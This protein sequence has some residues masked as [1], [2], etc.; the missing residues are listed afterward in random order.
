MCEPVSTGLLIASIATTA[1]AGGVSAYAAYDQGQYQKAVGEYNA[2]VN[3]NEAQ[4]VLNKSR[5]VES[6]E[7]QKASELRSRQRAVLASRG[8]DVNSGSALSMQEDTTLIGEM[9][10]MRVRQNAEDRADALNQRADLDLSNGENAADQGT[11]GAVAAGLKT[12]GSIAGT[13]S[14]SGLF[15]K[16]SLVTDGKAGVVAD[17]WYQGG[18]DYEFGQFSGG[19]S[20]MVKSF[21]F[22]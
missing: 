16:G 14:N 7:R 17:K 11:M 5:I 6:E 13:A 15:G 22:S 3:Q 20:S 4:K 19:S 12:A 21:N 2:R 10:V 18:S 9:N 1:V 8:A